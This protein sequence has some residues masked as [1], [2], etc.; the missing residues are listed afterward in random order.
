MRPY[1][2]STVK[3]EPGVVELDADL[4]E[5]LAHDSPGV[6]VEIKPRGRRAQ[7][8]RQTRQVT[9]AENRGRD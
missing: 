7:A 3:L 1:V 9:E 4:A 2:S 5:W 6:L 8:N